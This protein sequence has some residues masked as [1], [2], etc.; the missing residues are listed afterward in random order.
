M[1]TGMRTSAH[2]SRDEPSPLDLSGRTVGDYQVLRKLGQGG[3]GQVYLAE[4]ISLRRKVA[5]KILRPELAADARAIERFRREALTIAQASHAN[6]VQVFD[7]KEFD[8][9]LCLAM[10]YVEGRNLRDY[11][12]RK[13]PPDL[14]IALSIMRQVASALQRAS[15]VGIIHRDIKPENILLTRKG[16]AKVADFGLARDPSAEAA[17]LNLTQSGQ[18]MGTPLYMSPEQVEGKPIDCRTD[19][20]SFGIT[21]YFMLAGHPPFQGASALEVAVQHVNKPAP[22]LSAIRPDLPEG[23]C[24][25][26]HKMIAKEPQQR[27]QN[28]RELLRELAKLG[29]GLGPEVGSPA[30]FLSLSDSSQATTTLSAKPR[31]R[32]WLALT[33]VLSL[34]LAVAFGMVLAWLEQHSQGLATPTDSIKPSDASVVETILQPSKREQALRTLVEEALANG[35]GQSPDAS[36]FGNCMELAILYLDS[37]RLDEAEQLFTQLESFKSPVSLP[38][39]GQLGKGIVLALRNK[40]KESN[41]LFSKVLAVG[42][43]KFIGKGKGKKMGLDGGNLGAI[44][45]MLTPIAPFLNHP[46]GKY[47]LGEARLFN[48]RNGIPE[49]QV[50]RYLLVRYRLDPDSRK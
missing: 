9:M 50:S 46:R 31:G 10:E 41:A 16:E 20:Y 13:G 26:V 49:S 45:K 28:G 6:I 8:G 47:W 23:L 18:T 4:Q 43:P 21:C 7:F 11:V 44:Q 34:V 3:M 48:A 32:N 33:V 2:G 5:L 27:P 1:T 39:L 37:D 17:A 30:A 38:M 42:D 24:A 15:E 35:A 25:L 40:P 12:T 29:E 22:P 19:I 36:V 14:T